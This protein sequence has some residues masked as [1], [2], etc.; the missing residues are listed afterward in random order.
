MHSAFFAALF[1]LNWYTSPLFCSVP[2]QNPTGIS[3]ENLGLLAALMPFTSVIGGPLFGGISDATERPRIV[4]IC[5]IFFYGL[6]RLL[7]LFDQ[8][9]DFWTVFFIMLLGEA[10]GGRLFIHLF[11]V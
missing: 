7:F 2:A 5:L 9:H 10:A 8:L 1:P 6:N 3:K 11:V 4:M